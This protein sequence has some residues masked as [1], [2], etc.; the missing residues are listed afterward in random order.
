MFFILLHMDT[1]ILKIFHL[2]W[3]FIK[4]IL[5]FYLE[6]LIPIRILF[7]VIYE[8]LFQISYQCVH[9]FVSLSQQN[10]EQDSNQFKVTSS[11]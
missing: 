3:D 11:W 1:P 7:H 4:R 5:D 9:L 10:V 8:Y 2:K 6:N